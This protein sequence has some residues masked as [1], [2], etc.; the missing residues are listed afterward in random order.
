MRG[1][2]TRSRR[3]RRQKPAA[4]LG[5]VRGEEIISTASPWRVHP[6]PSPHAYSLRDGAIPREGPVP[7]GLRAR[8]GHCRRYRPR[9]QFGAIDSYTE[10]KQAG[11][12]L[13]LRV[14]TYVAFDRSPRPATKTAARYHLICW[15]QK[16][17][18]LQEPVVLKTRRATATA[19]TQP[20]DR[21]ADPARFHSEGTDREVG[22]ALGARDRAERSG[23]NGV[24]ARRRP[25][26]VSQHVRGGR[27][28]L[29]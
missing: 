5:S 20:A 4:G 3:G 7:E 21:K 19:S 12:K 8:D 11:V 25:R 29:E 17:R 28:L 15:P 27:L 22:G 2:H 24:A 10:A 18:R 9:Q 1:I 14:E 26:A 23:R 13:N 6:A 16:R